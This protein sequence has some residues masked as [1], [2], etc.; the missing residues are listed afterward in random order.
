M[1]LVSIGFFP[2]QIRELAGLLFIVV[3]FVL[4]LMLALGVY[5]E[6]SRR[7]MRGNRVWFVG[8]GLWS[9]AT[10]VGGITTAA[11]YWAIHHSK[12]APADA[13]EPE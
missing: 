6:A 10:F 7:L 9:F 1:Q 13:T 4:N 2:P 3:A 12:L 8:P 11:I 5:S